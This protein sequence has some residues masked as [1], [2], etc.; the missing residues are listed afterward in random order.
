MQSVTDTK[1]AVG[2]TFDSRNGEEPDSLDGVA[3]QIGQLFARSP[4]SPTEGERD[5]R[6]LARKAQRSCDFCGWCGRSFNKNETVWR[7]GIRLG[8]GFFGGWAWT[9][10]PV[11]EQ[12]RPRELYYRPEKPCEYCGRAV[13]NVAN[14]T[15]RRRKHTYCSEQCAKEHGS[16][17][18]KSVRAQRRQQREYF[19]GVC[20]HPFRPS[21][22]DASHC[23]SAC[24]QR[25]YRNRQ[26]E[27]SKK[28]T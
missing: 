5:R 28:Q 20:G 11:C 10:I 2:E 6:E 16:I 14:G 1:C 21:R 9:V 23:S 4:F 18:L 7:L 26:R 19:C 24:R 22:K 13:I 3:A 17:V 8:H 27:V 12:C 15:S 25:D